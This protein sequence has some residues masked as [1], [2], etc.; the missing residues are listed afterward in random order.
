MNKIKNAGFGLIE[1][2]VGASI[3]AIAGV[4]LLSA[5]SSLLAKGLREPHNLKAAILAEEGMEVIRILRDRG[6]S[7][8]IAPLAS[9]TSYHLYF[10]AT[11]SQWSATTTAELIDTIFTRVAVLGD[12]K[13]DANDRIADTGIVDANTRKVTV[14]VTW[15]DGLNAGEKELIGYITN[16]FQD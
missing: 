8:Y 6:W 12:V 2:V 10:D 3:I 16:M 14:R 5:Y 11:S 4:A 1:V 13:R 7:S 15:D 9:T